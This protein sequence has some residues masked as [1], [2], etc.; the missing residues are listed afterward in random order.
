[1]KNLKCFFA[2]LLV[3]VLPA[4]L[5]AQQVKDLFNE[6]RSAAVYLNC[7][8]PYQAAMKLLRE[9][10]SPA[11]S[12]LKQTFENLFQTAF[13]NFGKARSEA[14]TR[15]CMANMR[16]LLGGVEMYNMDHAEMMGKQL[17]I[18][19]LVDERYVKS[20]PLCPDGGVYS[21]QGDLSVDGQIQC[22][23][24][25]TVENPVF[26]PEKNLQ[27]AMNLETLIKK[28]LEF[29]QNG[30]FR[31][32]GG[33]YLVF[34]PFNSGGFAILIE[35]D[36]KPE[37]F[38]AFLRDTMQ[39]KMPE[40][41]NGPNGTKV[42]NY[43]VSPLQGAKKLKLVFSSKGLYV[44]AL[45][46]SEK[47]NP[48]HW[49]NFQTAAAK[50]EN[51]LVIE[52][53]PAPI[54]KQHPA[55]RSV[56]SSGSSS[57]A[58]SAN[59]RVLLGATEMYNMDATE[60]Q[61]MHKL[62]PQKLLEGKYLRSI[63]QCP[64]GGTYSQTGDLMGD[65]QIICS[66]HN[67]V[68]NLKIVDLPVDPS[69]P[70]EIAKKIQVLRLIVGEKSSLL[71]AGLTDQKA[72]EALKAILQQ[73]IPALKQQMM[74]LVDA[75]LQQAGSQL[76]ANDKNSVEIL[77]SFINS[78]DVFHKGTWTGIRAQGIPGNHLIAPA[79]GVLAAIAVPNFRKARDNA[80]QKACYAN[81]RVLMGAM[82]MFSMD[83]P[84]PMRS[85]N[86]KALLDGKYL[87]SE[88]KC[89]DGGEYSAE[90]DSQGNYQIKCTVH[91]SVE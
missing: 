82:E 32:T 18:Q 90:L 79:V 22:S 53:L 65:G 67:T 2:F 42:V 27:E 86:M 50:P 4:A 56:S 59:M 26:P 45:M 14:R 91:G 63:P 87:R 88:V 83:N 37:Q 81:Q 49:Q 77:K 61:E 41:E 43:Q 13:Q 75:R 17:D 1:M 72:L 38:I 21:N 23:I 19:K 78:I 69:T 25:G 70:Q 31:P 36:S 74:N 7:A 47:G 28:F 11:N 60:G 44:D 8:A 34:E 6:E 51:S 39:I 66:I 84:E 55:F 68:D 80:R 89:P 12:Q 71:G 52:V 30:L 10:D 58:C 29:D 64:N 20:L 48:E 76:S 35:A 73:Q 3:L 57:K 15:A 46:G 24:H 40:A 33:L 9:I 16:V 85:L 5:A 54:I 62:D